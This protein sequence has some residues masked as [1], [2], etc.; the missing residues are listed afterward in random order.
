MLNSNYFSKRHFSLNL[1][2]FNLWL[3]CNYGITFNMD[4]NYDQQLSYYH[5][6]IRFL[7]YREKYVQERKKQAQENLASQS[8]YINIIE[9]ELLADFDVVSHTSFYSK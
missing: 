1:K 8:D 2:A 4:H 9:K 6:Y 3:Q 7:N 5:S